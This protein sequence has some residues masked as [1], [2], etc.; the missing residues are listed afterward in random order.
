MSKINHQRGH[1]PRQDNQA[2]YPL[3]G[4]T[5]VSELSGRSIQAKYMGAGSDRQNARFQAGAKKYIRSR[6]RF[7]ENQMTRAL[8]ADVE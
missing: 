1:K 2:R 3:M 4:T 6:T 8:A 5:V 7:H